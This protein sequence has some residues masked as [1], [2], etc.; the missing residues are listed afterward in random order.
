MIAQATPI[1]PSNPPGSPSLVGNKVPLPHRFFLTDG[2]TISGDLHKSPTTRLADHLSTVKGFISV[3]GACCEATG[4]NYPHIVLNQ[5]HI[6]FIEE[7]HTR[8]QAVPVTTP[9][10]GG[11]HVSR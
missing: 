8:P 9:S 4:R 10:A 6:L 7:I 5:D 11:V 1:K 2:R 3:T